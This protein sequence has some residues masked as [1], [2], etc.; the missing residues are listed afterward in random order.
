ML[1]ER[2]PVNPAHEYLHACR[3]SCLIKTVQD[4][5]TKDNLSEIQRFFPRADFGVKAVTVGEASKL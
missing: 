5:R 1:A 4:M 2:G 3:S